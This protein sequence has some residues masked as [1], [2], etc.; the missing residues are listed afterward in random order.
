[1]ETVKEFQISRATGALL[2]LA[3][4]DALGTALEFKP[5]DSYTALTDMVGGGPFD[6]EPG[7]WTDDTSMMLCLADSL[8]EKGGMDLN[9]QM[10]RYVRWYRHGEN[11]C[12][13]TCFD[14][15]MTVQTALSSYERTGNPQSGSTS[16]FSAGNGSLMRVAPIAL[17]FAHDNEQHAMQ[18]A[19]LSS[20]T[21]HGEERCVQA[22]EIM[23]LLIHRLLNSEHIADREVFL[24]TTLTDYLQFSKDCHP[25]VRAIAEC[26]FFSKSRESIHGTGY[27]VAS[28][29]AALWCFVNSDSFEDGALLAANLGD[30]ADTT[31]AIF[32]Q[33]A[34]AYYG[35][36][37][38]PSKWQ[39]KLA[40]ES[41]ISDTAMWLLQRPTNQQVKDFVSEVSVHIERQDP[42]DIA[43]YS[44]AYDHDLMV[45]H[46]DYNAPF[47]V[48]DIDA[49]TDFDA[50]LRQASFRDCI[51]WM[52]RLVRTERFWDGVIVS[53]IRNGSVTRWLN[54]MHHLLSLHGE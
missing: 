11:S 39:L 18:A 38:I 50:W 13:G 48:N 54:N 21:T 28:L 52:I 35:V 19:N 37:A 4:G 23:T 2:G 17:F 46:I 26:Q 24:K 9:D 3:A 10:Q 53:N 8:I 44:M 7:Q 29:E 41:Q 32:G 31:A 47:Y 20:L 33:L 36:S 49:F 12:N 34:G 22:C 25:E 42:A 45:T 14:I 40:W 27:V 1:M 30:D 6:L 5:K 43:L 51:C 16:H 15:G